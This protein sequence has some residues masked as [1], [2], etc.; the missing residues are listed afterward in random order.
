MTI[1]DCETER[2]NEFPQKLRVRAHALRADVE[3]SEGGNDEA[4][5]AHD[6]FDAALAALRQMRDQLAGNANAH[7][8]LA[9]LSMGMS[10]DF[11]VAV[12]EGATMVRIGS[13]LFR[14]IGERA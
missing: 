10:N 5:G 4:P 1:I 6:Y 13:A 3:A 14:G 11:E 9:E 8:Q 12:E 7:C 2:P